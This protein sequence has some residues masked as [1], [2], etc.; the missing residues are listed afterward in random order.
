MDQRHEEP[1]CE[2]SRV[3]DSV[4]PFPP[5]IHIIKDSE[6]EDAG[7]SKSERPTVDGVAYPFKLGTHLRE[8]NANASTITLKSQAGIS[9]PNITETNEVL[10]EAPS[11]ARTDSR[12]DAGAKVDSHAQNMDRAEFAD[13]EAKRPKIERFTTAAEEL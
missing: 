1:K 2:Q 4:S 7:E 10:D 11:A 6:D 5:S 3:S 13:A 12:S 9:T 8:D